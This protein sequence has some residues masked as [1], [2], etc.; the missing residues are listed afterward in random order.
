MLFFP[1]FP[2]LLFV[3]APWGRCT[4]T[5][6]PGS[7]F[8]PAVLCAAFTAILPPP[9]TGETV[10]HT[11]TYDDTG[12]LLG[13]NYGGGQGISYTYDNSGNLLQRTIVVFT[14]TDTDFIDDTWETQF[15]GNADRD[16]S[17]DFDAD[18]QS[19]LADYLS[20]T[21]PTDQ[22]SLLRVS[23]DST[24]DE[25]GFMIEWDAA[26]GK[27]YQVQYTENLSSAAWF[28]LGSQVVASGTTA[29]QI[30]PDADTASNR[31]YRVVVLP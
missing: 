3:F 10:T 30:D 14:D 5:N 16:G 17:D 18:G 4:W 6:R 11:Y 27:L 21:D 1:G 12:R 9:L 24:L 15:F 23:G 28:N 19:D 2:L 29:S 8:L 13:V 22:N 7:R 20:G 25:N 26:P 31:F